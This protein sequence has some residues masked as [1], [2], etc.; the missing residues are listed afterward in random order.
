MEYLSYWRKCLEVI[1]GHP[2]LD[3]CSGLASYS[4]DNNNNNVVDISNLLLPSFEPGCLT[5]WPAGSA[6]GQSSTASN[7]AYKPASSHSL[8]I[9]L[10][11]WLINELLIT[12]E[13]IPRIRRFSFCRH[14][15][16]LSYGPWQFKN[17]SEILFSLPLELRMSNWIGA[18]LIASLS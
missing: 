2:Y 16:T 11:R 18:K 15:R 14:T 10:E 5:G 6:G 17:I 7:L 4:S 1:T 3:Q 13:Y 8:I 12:T 9:E